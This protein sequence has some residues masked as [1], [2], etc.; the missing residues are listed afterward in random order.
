MDDW[1]TKSGWYFGE[2][3]ASRELG[4]KAYRQVARLIERFYGSAANLE[5]RAAPSII[6]RSEIELLGVAAPRFAYRTLLRSDEMVGFLN[7]RRLAELDTQL[8]QIAYSRWNVERQAVENLEPSECELALQEL[9]NRIEDSS[10]IAESIL[11]V[12]SRL[13]PDYHIITRDYSDL[14]GEREQIEGTPFVNAIQLGGGLCSQGAFFMATLLRIDDAMFVHG[15]SEITAILDSPSDQEHLE[16]K[17]INRGDFVR[18]FRHPKVGLNSYWELGWFSDAPADQ[19]GLTPSHESSGLNLCLALRS[20]ILSNIPVIAL[21]N[22]RKYCETVLSQTNR[23]RAQVKGDNEKHCILIVGVGKRDGL[24]TQLIAHDPSVNAPWLQLSIA[25]LAACSME[26]AAPDGNCVVVFPVLPKD[27]KL[28]LLSSP[29]EQHFQNHTGLLRLS[30]SV[31]RYREI[32]RLEFGDAIDQLPA[33]RP[34]TRQFEE[35]LLLDLPLVRRSISEL[36]QSGS[37]DGPNIAAA[38]QMIT[39]L[40]PE[41][42]WVWIQRCN[43]YGLPYSQ[44]LWIWNAAIGGDE[45][46]GNL[47]GCLLAVLVHDGDG[48]WKNHWLTGIPPHRPLTGLETPDRAVTSALGDSRVSTRRLQRSLITS[49]LPT[50]MRI[51]PELW[52]EP[53]EFGVVGC[54]LY[55]FMLTDRKFIATRCAKKNSTLGNE[56]LQIRRLHELLDVIQR[57]DRPGLIEHLADAL[58]QLFP[59][60]ERPIGALASYIPEISKPRDL[61]SATEAA[62]ALNCLCR[63]A[64]ELKK[65]QQP[66]TAIEIVMG[67]RVVGIDWR[68][69]GEARRLNLKRDLAVT[70][71]SQ[72]RTLTWV[73]D[74]ISTA[75]TSVRDAMSAQ[76]LAM[77]LEVEP[78][79]LFVLKDVDSIQD[80]I[81]RIKATDLDNLVGFNLDIG[82]Y[83]MAKHLLRDHERWSSL[84]QLMQSRLIHCHLSQHS[85]KGHFGD[86]PLAQHSLG[87]EELELLRYYRDAV[88]QRRSGGLPIS[89][90]VSVEL[91]AADSPES[92][93]Q[94]LRVLGMA[95]ENLDFR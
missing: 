88:S 38:Y 4:E 90:Y 8:G 47:D 59:V 26:P 28:H 70:V 93:R 14:F 37:D 41:H 66:V 44:S 20:Y 16:L 50:S 55:G 17:G 53:D 36:R 87:V 42:R 3:K 11:P 33:V 32:G 78:G 79:E 86:G 10:P 15:P 7:C 60:H 81:T 30:Q 82:H 27:V 54:E 69:L 63:L 91:E 75:V 24:R 64:I 61:R 29:T 22:T 34:N 84:L 65:R 94:S 31:Q 95:L 25:E 68:W 71:E 72:S 13:R 18:Y 76:G 83:L 12:P 6:C 5:F 74:A 21:V 19:I 49:F 57:H 58:C 92:I 48:D 45:H 80:A 52:P 67:S 85:R 40:F 1:K 39:Q 46:R 2:C 56:L 51:V 9:K 77:A 62:G 35:V 89:G 43:H 73:I 23:F